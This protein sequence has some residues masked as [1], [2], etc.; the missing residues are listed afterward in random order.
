[1]KLENYLRNFV[2]ARVEH[3]AHEAEQRSECVEAK[4]Q[5]LPLRNKAEQLMGK[6]DVEELISMIRGCDIPIY[7]YC[8]LSGLVDS[9]RLKETLEQMQKT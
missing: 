9:M 6:D 2:S 8:Y 3:L 4:K 7:E 1:M 5:M